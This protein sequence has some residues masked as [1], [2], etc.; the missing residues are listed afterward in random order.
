[1]AA[2]LVVVVLAVTFMTRRRVDTDDAVE[3]RFAMGTFVSVTV[4]SPDAAVRRDATTAAFAEVERIEALTTRYSEDSEVSRLNS[5]SE[6]Y[7]GESVDPDVARLVEMSLDVAADSDGAFDIT[8]APL[9]ELWPLDD[10]DFSLPDVEAVDEALLSVDWQA[11]QVDATTNTM[12]VL[13]GT[14]LDLAGVAKGY[15]VDRAAAA[16][17]RAGV[18]RGMVDAGGDIGFVGTPPHEGWWYAGIKHPREEGLLGVVQLDGGS[19]ATSG[20]YQ[21]F[22][23]VGGVRYHHIIDPSTGW[24][25]R[26]LVSVTVVSESCALADALATAVFVMGAER[27]MAL[28]ERTPGAEAVIATA[29]GDD[30]GEVLLSSGLE[31]KF[32]DTRGWSTHELGQ[33]EVDMPVGDTR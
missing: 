6:G 7:A 10:E 16:L 12:T 26:G 19:V 33:S 17:E 23:E 30:V 15:A 9:V 27:G 29:D 24:P 5:L 32:T 22:V 25:A 20:D 1:V 11:V 14:R 13:P 4:T 31:D 8:V 3:H 2:L 21:R 18:V 28:I